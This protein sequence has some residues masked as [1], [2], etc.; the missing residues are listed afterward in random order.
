MEPDQGFPELTP[1]QFSA[2]E[3]VNGNMIEL[4]D[5]LKEVISRRISFVKP[6]K[7]KIAALSDYMNR[8]VLRSDSQMT[9]S[10]AYFQH[11]ANCF[12]HLEELDLRFKAPY[13]S[14]LM[15]NLEKFDD[16]IKKCL[17]GRKKRKREIHQYIERVGKLIL[18]LE[19]AEETDPYY[20]DLKEQS[21]SFADGKEKLTE[22]LRIFSI[23]ADSYLKQHDQIVEALKEGVANADLMRRAMSL[24]EL[25]MSSIT[26]CMKYADEKPSETPK[27]PFKKRTRPEDTFEDEMATKSRI[28][29]AQLLQMLAERDKKISSFE[30]LASE[31]ETELQKAIEEQRQI[32]ESLKDPHPSPISIP[33]SGHATILERIIMQLQKELHDVTYKAALADQVRTENEDL[34]NRLRKLEDINSLFEALHN[35]G[36]ENMGDVD[37]VIADR[38]K[39]REMYEQSMEKINS[40]K[41]EN[42]KLKG[43]LN[44]SLRSIQE[45]FRTNISQIELYLKNSLLNIYK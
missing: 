13:G 21:D 33:N 9:F 18:Y 22:L 25:V 17:E 1:A 10:P 31:R 23:A 26:E 44:D 11:F 6:T 24:V 27:I 41:E 28:T 37:R 19:E 30:K 34:K 12:Q 8:V 32:I 45:T 14:R 36:I 39:F 42:E 3:T 35:R 15:G 38:D 20:Q 4:I 7:L 16:Q 5:I 29:K 2:I 43:S 40:L